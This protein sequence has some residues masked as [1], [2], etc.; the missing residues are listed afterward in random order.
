MAKSIIY[1]EDARRALE[2]GMDLLAEAV[3]VTLGPKGRNV[4]LEKK[5]GAPQIVN[6]GITIAKEIELEDHIENTGVALIRQAAS[7]TNDVAGDGTTTATV[8]AHAIVKEGLRNVAAGANPISLKKGIDKAA[9]FLVSQIAKHAKP[10]ED[11]KAIA[12][13]GAISAGND[14]EV[15]Q[16][17]ASAMDKV[18]KEGVISLEEG[19]SMT[20][21]LEITEG[22]RFDKGYISP[23]F[24]TDTERMECVFEDPA[25]LITDKKIGLVQDLVPIL[26]QVARQGKPLVIIAEDIEKEALATLVVNRLRGVLNVTAVKA[27]GFGDRRKA[28]LEDIAVL[29]GGQVISEDAGLKLETTKI[30]SLGTAR[31]ITMNKDTTTIVAEGNDVAVKTRCEQIRRQIEETDSSYDKEKLQERL[32]KLAGGVAVIKV[33]AATETEMKDRKLRLEDAINA[34]KAAVEEGIVPGGGTTLAHLAPQ[35]ETWAKETLHHEELTGALIVSRAIAAPLK[36]IAENAGQNGAVI[37]ERVKEK[38]FNVGYNAATGEFSDMFE[39]GIVDPAKVTRSALQNA[40]S[41][42]GM[43]LTTECIVVDKPEKEK[44]AAPGGGGDFDY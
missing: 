1:N 35:L 31:R 15:G 23:Y 34:T 6:D 2:K 37:A 13:V 4:V 32:A 27:P 17:I 43:V 30:D 20:T 40:A 7:K 24:V 19:K 36:R 28:M 9:D 33:G 44:A 26:E 10:V 22:M 38:P 3:A 41:I 14:D 42:A 18:G 25:I 16:M 29:T 11:S 21:E 8:L 39:A 12:Q 5:F